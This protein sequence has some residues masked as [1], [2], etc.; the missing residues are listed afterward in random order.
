MMPYYADHGWFEYILPH[1]LR[2]FSNPH[3]NTM[4]DL[5]LRNF[6]KLHECD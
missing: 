5:D 1:R 6:S 4:T 3:K 2:Y